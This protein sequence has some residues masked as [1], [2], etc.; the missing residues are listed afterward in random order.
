MGAG[1][2]L[3]H[4]IIESAVYLQPIKMLIVSTELFQCLHKVGGLLH[5]ALHDTVSND[6]LY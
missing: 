4:W 6:G 2:S 5:C 3:S 1:R